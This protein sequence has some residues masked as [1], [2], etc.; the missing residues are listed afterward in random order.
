[1][2]RPCKRRR[3]C[4][5]P[6]CASFGPHGGASTEKVVMT[7]DEYE[8]IRLIDALGMNQEECAKQMAVARTT[9]QAIY[10]SA[11]RKLAACLVEGWHLVIAGGEYEVCQE[12]SRGCGCHGGCHG[13]CP[14]S[15]NEE[16]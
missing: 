3:I 9:V 11:R 15:N 8:T 10:T 16:R 13:H 5:E 7:L 2:P 14:H 4:G 1:M 6:K 12:S